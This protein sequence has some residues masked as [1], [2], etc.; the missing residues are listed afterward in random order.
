M[1]NVLVSTARRMLQAARQQGDQVAILR[2][3]DP[4]LA[5]EQGHALQARARHLSPADV[6]AE[7]KAMLRSQPYE[8]MGLLA[9]WIT[10][11]EFHIVGP[12]GEHVDQVLPGDAPTM[13]RW[14]FVHGLVPVAW[15]PTGSSLR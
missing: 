3:Q 15:L 1:S 8:F 12:D 4:A 7:F 11:E 2:P 10:V 6:D 14:C 9:E 5:I 13:L